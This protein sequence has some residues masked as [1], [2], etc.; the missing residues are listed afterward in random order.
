MT[1]GISDELH[2]QLGQVGIKKAA[3]EPLFN[4]NLH[5]ESAWLAS[6]LPL[7]F[8]W[9]CLA[10]RLQRYRCKG[11][12]VTFNALTGTPLARLHKRELWGAAITDQVLTDRSAA[13]IAAVL[14]PVAAKSA[15]LVSDAAKAY[16]AFA[17][18]ARLRPR[19]A[20][21][22]RGRAALGH[23]P[24]PE[25]QRL[26]EPA[27]TLAAPL[28]RRRHQ[29]ARHQVARQ[30]P[31]LAPPQRARRRHALREPQPGVR[32]QHHWLTAPFC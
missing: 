31:R 17:R 7:N 24:H 6:S 23:L 10:N 2:M 28:Q 18:K 22:E 25:C 9:R 27:E 1:H 19:P 32:P 20:Q 8:C 5:S 11:C 12:R 4:F 16:R 21:F 3:R 26:H 14:G 15:I 30:L 29:V 13:A